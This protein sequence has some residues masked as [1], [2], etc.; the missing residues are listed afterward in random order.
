[1]I[2]P[3][4]NNRTRDRTYHATLLLAV[5]AA[6]Y[7]GVSLPMTPH[8]QQEWISIG[9]ALLALAI[10]TVILLVAHRQDL[11]QESH[12]KKHPALSIRDLMWAT[13]VVALL[14]ALWRSHRQLEEERQKCRELEF[15]LAI[16]TSGLQR[17]EGMR[18]FQERPQ[19]S[20]E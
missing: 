11:I 10:S 12:Y 1:M 7:L 18:K 13:V 9:I 20:N 2:D 4:R 15:R 3:L 6:A 5:F 19:V 8:R 14:L 17:V 16:R